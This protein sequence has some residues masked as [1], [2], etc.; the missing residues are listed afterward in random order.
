MVKMVNEDGAK[1]DVVEGSC[2]RVFVENDVSSI[3]LLLK[4]LNSFIFVLV[5]PFIS[6]EAVNI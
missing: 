3:C 2:S 6:L 5:L 1:E 4:E